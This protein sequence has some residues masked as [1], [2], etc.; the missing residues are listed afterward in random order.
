[1]EAWNVKYKSFNREDY[2]EV[3]SG[4]DQKDAFKNAKKSLYRRDDRDIIQHVTP[5]HLRNWLGK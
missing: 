5:T 3:V 4:K 1:M 2:V